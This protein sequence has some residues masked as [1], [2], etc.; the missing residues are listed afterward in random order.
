MFIFPDKCKSCVTDRNFCDQCKDSLKY[1]D[2]PKR[3]LFTAYKPACPFGMNHCV[4]DPAYIQKYDPE[5]YKSLYGNIRP[6]E[7][8][9]QGCSD[10]KSPDECYDD[11]DK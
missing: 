5:W 2:V 1:R 6:E 8:V 3:S 4:Y 10:Y 9:K 7:A 11:E